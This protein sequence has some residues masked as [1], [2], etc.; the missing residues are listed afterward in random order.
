VEEYDQHVLLPLL[1]VVSKHLNPR[2]MESPPL[3]PINDDS[4]WGVVVF[5]EEDEFSLVKFELSCIVSNM[6][7]IMM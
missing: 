1:V 4:L 7:M 3:A 6:W 5:I 2:C